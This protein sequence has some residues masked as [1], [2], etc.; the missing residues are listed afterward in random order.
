[1]QART[2]QTE[3]ESRREARKPPTTAR[4]RTCHVWMTHSVAEYDASMSPEVW[5]DRHDTLPCA[6]KVLIFVAVYRS[7]TLMVA[8]TYPT[9]RRLVACHTADIRETQPKQTNSHHPN[10]THTNE[11]LGPAAV[12]PIHTLLYDVIGKFFKTTR[13]HADTSFND[14]VRVESRGSNAFSRQPISSSSD[15]ITAATAKATT[16]DKVWATRQPRTHPGGSYH[17]T[18]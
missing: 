16:K 12:Q 11:S 3:T 2:L 8:S 9:A 18:R 6:L 7:Y 4:A 1:M 10:K 15:G 13:K 17:H 14:C 5:N